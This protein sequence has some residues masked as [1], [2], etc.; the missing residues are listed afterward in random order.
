LLL[1]AYM[2]GLDASGCVKSGCTYAFAADGTV[3]QTTP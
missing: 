2:T 3:T 1:S